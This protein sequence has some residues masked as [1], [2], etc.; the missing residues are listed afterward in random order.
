[1][2]SILIASF[3]QFYLPSSKLDYD[4]SKMLL[5]IMHFFYH[6]LNCKFIHCFLNMECLWLSN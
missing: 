4:D 3:L 2:T 6:C 5:L 1:M